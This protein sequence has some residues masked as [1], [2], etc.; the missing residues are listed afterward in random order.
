MVTIAPEM[1]IR[2]IVVKYPQAR[3]ILEEVGIDYCC[4][5][6]KRLDVAAKENEVVVAD[7]IAAFQEAVA[8][9]PAGKKTVEK[10]NNIL[11]P[12]AIEMESA[13]T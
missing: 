6:S 13:K 9:A 2:E 4:G 5:G 8:R 12:R 1:T 3:S 11:F 7:I 10:E